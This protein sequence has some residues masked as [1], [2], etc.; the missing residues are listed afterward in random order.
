MAYFNLHWFDLEIHP[1]S[2]VNKSVCLLTG[3]KQR[4]RPFSSTGDGGGKVCPSWNGNQV[5]PF[6]C[7]ITFLSLTFSLSLPLSRLQHGPSS[8]VR[9]ACSSISRWMPSMGSRP[10]GQTAALRWGSSLTTAVMLSPQVR[11]QKMFFCLLI[12]GA[13]QYLTKCISSSGAPLYF[14]LESGLD[15]I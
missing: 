5:I 15:W 2:H 12:C 7:L 4:P 14:C 8:W 13:L 10:G 9:W 11:A 1:A 6:P 3:S